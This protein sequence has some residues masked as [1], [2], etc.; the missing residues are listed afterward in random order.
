M[1]G[2]PTELRATD[3]LNARLN[4][5][6]CLLNL[7]REA[8]VGRAS[9]DE[10]LFS[11]DSLEATVTVIHRIVFQAQESALALDEYRRARSS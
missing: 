5:A 10:P 1:S 8:L 11:N 4:E 6:E 3:T 2:Q 7:L 9:A